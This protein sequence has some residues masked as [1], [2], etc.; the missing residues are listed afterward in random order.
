MSYGAYSPLMLIATNGLIL[1]QGLVPN[2]N[3]V[4]GINQYSSVLPIADI[5]SVIAN[6]IP[7]VSANLISQSTFD[8]IVSLGNTNFPGLTDAIPSSYTANMV[9]SY[10]NT[11]Y[12]TTNVIE[13]QINRLLGNFDGSGYN[14]SIFSQI[15]YAC[16]AYQF[17]TN[18]ILNS[19]TN[20]VSLDSTFTDMNAL[21]SGGVSNVNTEFQLFGKD[22]KNLGKLINPANLANLGQP[23]ALLQQMSAVGGLIPAIYTALL[24]AGV[25]NDDIVQSNALSAIT[26]T[27]NK[28]IY[29]ALGQITG[30]NLDQ[31]LQLLDVKTAGITTAADL[32]NPLKLFPTSYSTLVTQI[33][34]G[35]TTLPTQQAQVTI[36]TGTTVNSALFAAYST[37]IEF[38]ALSRVIPPDQAAANI[39]LRHSLGQVNNI[40]NAT[41][42]ALAN[43]VILLESNTDLGLIGNLTSPIPPAVSQSLGNLAT[44][45]NSSS[46]LTMYDFMGVLTGNLFIGPLANLTTDITKLNNT[47][48]LDV[49]TN[50]STGLYAYMNLALA[51]PSGN[52]VIPS[53]PAIGDYPNTE[54]A[55][56]GPGAPGIGLLPATTIEIANIA[57]SYPAIVSTTTSNINIMMSQLDIENHNLSLAGVDFTILAEVGNL[58]GTSIVQSFGSSLHEIGK[59]IAAG[60]PAQFVAAISD[61]TTQPGQAVIATMREGR[62]L[63]ALENAGVRAD[64]QIPAT[65]R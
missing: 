37:D 54:I 17:T 48:S 11:I 38:I 1:N 47:G 2:P 3:I 30:T 59:D 20:S 53:G 7:A 40:K 26:P 10:G 16:Y 19:V 61:T 29:V 65:G 56:T 34:S 18:T 52:V 28:K 44:G 25:T 42:P 8:S 31:I 23:Y 32:L 62:N 58:A 15:Y 60:G 14:L 13:T 6:A 35:T 49:L 9:A 63:A 43:S 64:T 45:S 12:G 51:T 36:Y 27:L 39:A 33:A 41:L 4:V 21:T 46:T 57:A 55:F 5:Q 50:P 22:L 24:F